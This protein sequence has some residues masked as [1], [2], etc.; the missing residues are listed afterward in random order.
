MDEARAAG[1]ADIIDLEIPDEDQ[2]EKELLILEKQQQKLIA[3]LRKVYQDQLDAN[4]EGRRAQLDA[5]MEERVRRLNFSNAPQV[6]EQLDDLKNVGA[7]FL[8]LK[9][10]LVSS[11]SLGQ[12]LLHQAHASE[13]YIIIF[14]MFVF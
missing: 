3:E 5:E 14:M 8:S 2:L 10:V 7:L 4:G 1:V 9:T 11:A 6:E 13:A 12:Q